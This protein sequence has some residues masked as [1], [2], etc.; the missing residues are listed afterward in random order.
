MQLRSGSDKSANLARLVDAVRRAAGAGAGLLVAPEAAMHGYGRPTT[1]LA[2]V[3]EALDGPFVSGLAAVA[4]ETGVTVVAGLFEAGA[5]RGRVYNTVTVVGPSGLM[6]RYRKVHLYD[7]LGWCESARMAPG[8]P[9]EG[10][11]VVAV[12]DLRLG[13]MTCFDLRFPEVARVLADGG[14]TAVAVPAAWVAGPGKAEQWEVLLRARAIEN[15]AYVL[16]AAQPEPEY[17]GCSMVVDPTG[18]V[19]ARL[20]G[21]AEG[22]GALLVADVRPDRVAE[23]RAGMPL[24]EQ[25]RF[26]VRPAPR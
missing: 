17:T 21:P 24:L 10:L 12:G 23:V 1:D 11:P 26:V 8:D 5:P 13:V 3:A 20:G 19:T 6:A 25:R 18:V 15:T 9:A 16:G 7:A 22:P 14:A 4:A 2:P